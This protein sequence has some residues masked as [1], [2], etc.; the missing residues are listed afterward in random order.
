MVQ[1]YSQSSVG[2]IYPDRACTVEAGPKPG[3][4]FNQNGQRGQFRAACPGE[5]RLM[6]VSFFATAQGV[7]VDQRSNG[8]SLFNVI[9]D[10]GA[11]A[12]PFILPP[13]SL[14]LSVQREGDEPDDVLLEIELKLDDHQLISAKVNGHFQGRPMLRIVS[15][16][17]GILVPAPGLLNL[18]VR[19]EGEELA[20]WTIRLSHIGKPALSTD[21]ETAVDPS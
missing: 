4:A 3:G 2:H 5:A 11:P 16:L 6:R 19:Y 8:L 18:F 10:L 17:Q 14:A 9:E 15:D 12:F 20:R 13:L 21:S 7:V 1:L